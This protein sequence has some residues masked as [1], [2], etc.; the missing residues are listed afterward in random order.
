[1]MIIACENPDLWSMKNWQSFRGWELSGLEKPSLQIQLG[2]TV[3]LVIQIQYTVADS[4][5]ELN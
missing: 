2:Y 1:M 3:N 5:L 4:P